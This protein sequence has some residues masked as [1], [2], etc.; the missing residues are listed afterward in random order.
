MNALRKVTLHPTPLND[1]IS[2]DLDIKGRFLDRAKTNTQ[3]GLA[4]VISVIESNAITDVRNIMRQS[5][6]NLI[7]C[8]EV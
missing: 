7:G 4:G 2:N 3:T 6:Q 5:C 8:R 1:G